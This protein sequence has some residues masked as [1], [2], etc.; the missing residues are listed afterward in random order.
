VCVCVC[1]CVCVRTHARLLQSCL[2]LCYPMDCSPP[3]S[4]VHR[5]LQARI[6]EWI[7]IPFSRGSS[8]PR[9]WTQVS[10]RSCIVRLVL[11]HWH[12]LGSYWT[13]GHPKWPYLDLIICKD[14]FQ[15][16]AHPQILEVRTVTF[17]RGTQ[18]NP[19]EV[20]WGEWGAWEGD[21]AWMYYYP[22]PPP[23]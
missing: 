5:I 20:K 15:M 4:T 1:V 16:Q 17:C 18:F 14:Y 6:V 10:Y 9:D 12:H 13:R 3:G 11:Y 8:R 21:Y 23:P 22:F 19:W 7:A 2:T